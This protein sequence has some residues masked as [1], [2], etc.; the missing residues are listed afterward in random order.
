MAVKWLCNTILDGA[1]IIFMMSCP[2]KTWRL[3]LLA[4]KS[5]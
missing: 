4:A 3:T 1:K 2:E 5:L